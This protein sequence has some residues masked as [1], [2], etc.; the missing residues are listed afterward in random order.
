MA[1]AKQY[2]DLYY[3]A[4]Y[5]PGCAP[6]VRLARPAECAAWIGRFHGSGCQG[7][8]FRLATMSDART[9]L[10]RLTEEILPLV[11]LRSLH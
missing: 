3:G 4:A 9:Q 1:D 6:G 5:L 2:L 7:F 8:T 10:R 11:S